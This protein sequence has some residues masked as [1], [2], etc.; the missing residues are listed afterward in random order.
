MNASA[1]YKAC[2]TCRERAWPGTAYQRLVAVL[3]LG[4]DRVGH[5]VYSTLVNA[6]IDSLPHLA[7]KSTVE[8]ERIGGLGASSIE[9]IRAEVPE[10]ASPIPVRAAAGS[11]GYA[12]VLR[13]AARRT[14]A[15][16]GAAAPKALAAVLTGALMEAAADYDYAQRINE[17]NPDG[18]GLEVPSL[19]AEAL[20]PV[21]RV[22]LEAL[23]T[24]Y[25]RRTLS[26]A[27]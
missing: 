9:R 27:K 19:T 21:A 8:L 26:A 6:G 17:K 16:L 2:D 1:A 4:H 22:L 25:S 11:N 12:T 20:L 10:P 23:G 18:A 3:D 5:Y 13:Q 7:A 15:A 14:D 24:P